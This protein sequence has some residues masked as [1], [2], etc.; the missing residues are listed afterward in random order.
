VDGFLFANPTDDG[1]LLDLELVT[2][3]FRRLP[4]VEDHVMCT[5]IF[6]GVSG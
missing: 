4:S 1:L 2:W 3:T 6:R 5:M